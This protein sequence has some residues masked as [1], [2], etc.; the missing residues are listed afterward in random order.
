MKKK[1]I[2]ELD[3]IIRRIRTI[4]QKKPGYKDILDFFKYI[5]RQQYKIKPMIKVQP[6]DM[7]EETAKHHIKEGFPL[8]DKRDI[9]LDMDAAVI[10]FIKLCSGL[11]RK[12]VNI[13]VEAK[14]ISQ[15]VRRKDLDIRELIES[16]L[17]GDEGYVDFAANKAGLH[18]W[19]LTYLAQSS[20]KPFFEA[21]AEKLKG[22][23]DQESWW[24][25]YCPVCGSAPATGELRIEAGE[26][27]LQCSTCSFMWRF[28]RVVCPF[29]GND[30]HEKLRYFNTE[31]NGKGYRVDVC[32]EC[33]KYIKTFDFRE[34][35]EDVI[36]IV[37]DMGTLHLDM[38]AEK[39]GY[40][41]GVPGFLE[42]ERTN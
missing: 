1:R 13:A 39:Q 24:K 8:I 14:K 5:T 27:Y 32:E 31:G 11:Q 25:G 22:Y 26:R 6:I 38:I 37:D 20:I 10:L 33:K 29:C 34:V 23:V 28:K 18:K 15:A 21:Y 3:R 12:D 17:N 35:R 36:P 41:R 4:V 9:K 30:N 7:N 19:L 42:V 16:V 2:Q 40:T